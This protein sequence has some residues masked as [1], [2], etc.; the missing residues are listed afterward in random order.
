MNPDERRHEVDG[1]DYDSARRAR[2][3]DIVPNEHDMPETVRPERVGLDGRT[4]RSFTEHARRYGI[5]Q[6]ERD[7]IELGAEAAFR[8]N[9]GRAFGKGE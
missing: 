3:D 4:Y 5:T 7:A 9:A 6:F 8:L 1:R 2:F